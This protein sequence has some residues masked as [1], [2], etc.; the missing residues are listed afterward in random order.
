MSQFADNP[1]NN[2]QK[3]RK[4][5]LSLLNDLPVA[6]EDFLKERPDIFG[7]DENRLIGLLEELENISPNEE[8][9]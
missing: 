2:P 9:K 8:L 6:D 1:L 5:W 3:P 4:D 7:F